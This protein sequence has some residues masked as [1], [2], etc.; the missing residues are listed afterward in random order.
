M[1]YNKLSAESKKI[2]KFL[3]NEKFNVKHKLNKS[4]I[5][6]IKKYYN[7]ITELYY[8]YYKSN[9]IVSKTLYKKLSIYIS[10]SIS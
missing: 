9:T 6:T 1:N 2:I 5:K 3:Q 8:P 7:Q 4:T 10:L